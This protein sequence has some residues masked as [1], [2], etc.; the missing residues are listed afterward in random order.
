MATPQSWF[1]YPKMRIAPFQRAA[2][3]VT[4]YA[5]SSASFS[6]ELV[7]EARACDVVFGRFST[8]RQDEPAGQQAL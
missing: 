5:A 3:Q 1:I 6:S 8:L 4:A 7:R 2:E